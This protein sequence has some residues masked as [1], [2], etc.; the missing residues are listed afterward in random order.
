MGITPEHPLYIASK[1]GHADVVTALIAAGADVNATWHGYAGTGGNAGPTPWRCG[2]VTALMI[3]VVMNHHP[4]VSVLV[5]AGADRMKSDQHWEIML[6]D[7]WVDEISVILKAVIKRRQL[8][9]QTARKLVM[10]CKRE[11]DHRSIRRLGVD[12][13]KIIASYVNPSGTTPR[14][15]PLKSSDV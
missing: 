5:E 1:R 14:L 2:P 6:G 10:L 8:N 13:V 9:R 12:A 7:S 15:A 11:Y 3:A 4:V